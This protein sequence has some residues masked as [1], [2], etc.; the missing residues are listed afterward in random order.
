MTWLYSPRLHRY[1]FVS[2]L[3][4]SLLLVCALSVHG[5]QSSQN[6][7][8]SKSANKNTAKLFSWVDEHG[9]VHY[10][11]RMPAEAAGQEHRLINQQGITVQIKPREKTAEEKRA[12]AEQLE[13]AKKAEK[14]KQL[15][16]RYDKNL[17]DMYANETELDK[18]FNDK[19]APILAR[20]K[21]NNEKIAQ[22]QKQI[23]ELTTKAGQIEL[24]G[25]QIPPDIFTQMKTLQDEI[26]KAHD[27]IAGFTNDIAALR[28]ATDLDLERYRQLKSDLVTKS[29]P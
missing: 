27:A 28:K 16:A 29:E 7:S 6:K 9:Q 15:Q 18:S 13:L 2:K 20:I 11:D 12:V 23:A 8:P 21:L 10:G 25:K 19:S 24:S 26:V 22:N 17:L 5:A 14:Q 3:S 1:N 4:L